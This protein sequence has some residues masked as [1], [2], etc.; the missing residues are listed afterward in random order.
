MIKGA[1]YRALER[2]ANKKAGEELLKSDAK[3]EIEAMKE[4]IMDDSY[5]T[6]FLVKSDLNEV[7]NT[8]KIIALFQ[9][10]K[11][12][13][14]QKSEELPGFLEYARAVITALGGKKDE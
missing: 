7:S 2:I 6:P 11:T 13:K 1:G 3:D 8:V 12:M 5:V 4:A 10:Y 9:L 14:D